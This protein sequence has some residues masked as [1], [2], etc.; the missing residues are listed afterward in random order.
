MSR[1][2]GSALS[3]KEWKARA[4]SVEAARPPRCIQCGGAKQAGG[5][6]MIVGH[7]LRTRS[8]VDLARY[9]VDVTLR[10]YRCRRCGAVMTVG[11]AEYSPRRQYTLGAIAL[12][13]ALWSLGEAAEHTVRARVSVQWQIADGTL[14]R[15]PVLRRWARSVPDLFGISD[16]Y[17]AAPRAVAARVCRVLAARA[18]PAAQELAIVDR[19]VS[20]AVGRRVETGST[21]LIP[22]V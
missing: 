8:V 16:V 4:L 9:V 12:A 22:A 17:E 14:K 7:G 15:W 18:P 3:V 2:I 13:L 11:P 10:R 6:V 21:M 1:F 5:R 20:G 19:A